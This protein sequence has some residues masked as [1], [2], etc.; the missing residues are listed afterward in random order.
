MKSFREALR[1]LKPGGF[2]LVGYVDKESEL[3]QRY[4]ANRHKSRFYAEA[5]FFSTAEVLRHLETAGFGSPELRQTLI[6][7]ADEQAVREGSGAG[8]FVVIRAIK[9]DSGVTQP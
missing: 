5:T 7:G 8:A 9:P 2:I 3:G 1:V 6:P 4:Q